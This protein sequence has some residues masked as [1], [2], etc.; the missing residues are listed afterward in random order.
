[1]RSLSIIVAAAG[2][3]V[4]GTL[5]AGAEPT[6]RPTGVALVSPPDGGTIEN[7][8][9]A[10]VRWDYPLNKD[11]VPWWDICLEISRRTD[12]SEPFIR[13][14]LKDDVTEYRFAALPATTYYWRITPFEIKDGKRVELIQAAARGRFTT[15]KP[16]NRAGAP[17]EERYRNPRRGAHWI[18]M[19][20]VP[21]AEEEPLAPWYAI[22]S[23]RKAPPPT[24]AQVRERFPV[25]V[26]DGHPRELDAY[27][28]CWDTMLRVWTYAPFTDQ[29]QAVSNLIGYPNWGAWGSTMIFDTCF[30]LHFARYGHQAYPF[31]TGLDNVYARQHE[32]GYICRE[33]DKDNREVSSGF[34]VNPP[35]LAWAEWENYRIVGDKDRLRAVF[36]PLVR[37]YEWW[38]THQ[39]RADGRYWTHGLQEADDSPRNTLMHAAVSATSYQGLAA[40]FLA[41]MAGELGRED[42]H[43]FFVA[44]N[45]ELKQLI[46]RSF[47]DEKHQI[48]NDL[49]KEG[50]PI[51]ELQPGVFCKHVHMFWPLMAGF[52]TPERAAGLVREL[53]NPQS[54]NRLTGVPSLSADSAGYNTE[55]GQYWRGAV[56]PSAQCMVQEGLKR[57]GYLQDLQ[58]LAEK[59]YRAC[60]ADYQTHK[61][62]R[63]NMAP[64]AILGCGQPDFVGWSGIGPV[65]NLVEYI[66]GLDIDAPGKIITWTIRQNERH[67]LTNLRFNGFQVDL[68]AAPA[69]DNGPRQITVESGGEFTLRLRRGDKVVAERIAAGTRKIA[70]P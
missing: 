40:Q 27:W 69:T 51:T 64:D 24:L 62:L 16:L 25:P 22:K 7:F 63:E 44:Q 17:D 45:E 12:W 6:S 58:E 53:R 18:N 43:A 14:D 8:L 60:V 28:Y 70:V 38:M 19:P 13:C 3:M 31:I 11:L 42:L 37:H 41:N 46:N 1:V 34:P 26:W 32:N 20:A 68:I 65:A 36:L 21:Y 2:L 9:T 52:A 61:T 15:G 54:F 10:V 35:L 5:A 57:M 50:R 33:S 55:N 48:Y 23:Y 56:W 47:W 67:G 66:L 49:D 59:Y 30:M 39:R 4:D 29:H